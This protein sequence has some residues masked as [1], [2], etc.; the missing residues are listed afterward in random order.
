MHKQFVGFGSLKSARALFTFVACTVRAS[1]RVRPSVC[2]EG[3]ALSFSKENGQ[4]LE[5]DP[6]VETR[7]V[8]SFWFHSVPFIPFTSDRHAQ[9][10]L[11]QN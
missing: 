6:R 2:E 7:P 1:E 8:A 9:Q 5:E 11:V 3:K 10:P 4:S